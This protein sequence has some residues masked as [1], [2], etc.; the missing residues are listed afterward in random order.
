[1]NKK[2][3][4]DLTKALNVKAGSEDLRSKLQVRIQP[5][6]VKVL[7]IKLRDCIEI[8]NPENEKKLITTLQSGWNNDEMNAIYMSKY[9]REKLGVNLNQIV[10]ISKTKEKYAIVITFAYIDGAK[11]LKYYKEFGKDFENHLISKNSILKIEK[12]NHKFELEVIDIHPDTGNA[13]IFEGTGFRFEKLRF[14]DPILIERLKQATAVSNKVRLD[15]FKNFLDLD[16]DNFIDKILEWEKEFNFKIK[17]EYIHF[18]EEDTAELIEKLKI[19]FEEWQKTEKKPFKI[20]NSISLGENETNLQ[21]EFE[22]SQQQQDQLRKNDLLG[23]LSKLGDP[24]AGILLQYRALTHLPTNFL[25]SF[26]KIKTESIK[27]YRK[28]INPDLNANIMAERLLY[29]LNRGRHYRRA[30]RYSIRK[31]MEAGANGVEVIIKI[32]INTNKYKKHILRAGTLIKSQKSYSSS[33]QKATTHSK[34]TN[35][36]PP[37]FYVAIHIDS[38]KKFKKLLKREFIPKDYSIEE[39]ECYEKPPVEKY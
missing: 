38:A 30:S 27:D 3:D 16:A 37:K 29:S 10:N 4:K 18:V 39:S 28:E 23:I 26:K 14:D 19:K 7:N 5:E 35:L 20:K 6:S 1:M 8:T 22:S 32:K 34:E 36:Q 21:E 2:N 24:D 15:N 12:Y 25:K 31:T 13:R 11:L 17:G 33:V 9:Q